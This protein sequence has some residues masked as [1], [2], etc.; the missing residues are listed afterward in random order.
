M[1]RQPVEDILTTIPQERI[2]FDNDAFDA[3]LRS[4]GVKLV[5][6]QAMRC[7]VGM[8]AL[9][10]NRR[11]HE[12]H[13]GCTNGFIYKKVG[14]ITALFVGNSKHKNPSDLGYWDGSTVQVS[15]PRYYD[16]AEDCPADDKQEI[17]VAPFDRF[18]LHEE[19]IVVPTWQLFLHH[20]SGIDRLKYPPIKVQ[21]L[22]DSQGISYT[23]GADFV[24][25]SNQLKWIGRQPSEQM[26]VGP[27]LTTA[28]A[29]DGTDPTDIAGINIQNSGDSTRGSVC[30]VRY[31]YRP[32]WYVGQIIHE[33]RVTQETNAYGDRSLKRA[34]QQV[35]LHREYVPLTKQADE[36]GS[37]GTTSSDS[38]RLMPG[39]ADGG[40]G[41][42]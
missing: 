33:I 13:A 38:F 17:F 22:M 29:P 28:L 7:P 32:F 35:M 9:D 5:H 41:P 36:P 31:L 25:F 18:Y 37:P 12:D 23:E 24:M 27:G 1:A 10:D 16:Q 3:M 20:E 11:P 39:P 30:S 8:T 6:Y 42:K 14:V 19:S 15:F 26:T 21:A 2:S 4:Q 34:P 40:F